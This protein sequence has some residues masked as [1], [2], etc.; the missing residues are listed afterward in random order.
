MSRCG[1]YLEIYHPYFLKHK[2]LIKGSHIVQLTIV[3]YNI[4]SFDDDLVYNFEKKRVIIIP[5][6]ICPS[7]PILCIADVIIAK[8]SIIHSAALFG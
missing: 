8:F 4:E 7:G 2:T 5:T 6:F 3:L 1:A